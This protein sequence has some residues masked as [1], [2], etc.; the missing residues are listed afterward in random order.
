MQPSN[1]QLATYDDDD[2]WPLTS[3]HFDRSTKA[4]QGLT[5]TEIIIIIIII[6]ALAFAS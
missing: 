2:D 3:N 6:F 5:P 1:V 4:P